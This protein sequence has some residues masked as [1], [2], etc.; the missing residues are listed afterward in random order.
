M[1][2]KNEFYFYDLETTGLSPK[3]DRIMQF[4]GQRTDMN[5]KPIGEPDNIF[6]K[7]TPDILPSPDAIMVTGIT[8]QQTLADGISE[9]EF[10]QYFHEHVAT[11]GTVF[12]GYNTVRFDDEFMRFL[13]YRNFYDAYTWQWRDDRGRWDLLD[14]V[15][16]TRA[17]R[18]AGMQWPV[19]GE[20]K[21]TNRLE[22]LTKVNGLQ[23]QNAHDALSDVSATI[24]IASLIKQQQPKLFSYLLGIR[25]K[26]QVQKI[27]ASGQPFIYT[28]GRYAAEF[29][30]T[31]VAMVVGEHPLQQGS[32]FVFD[33]RN[34]PTE[35]IGMTVEDI[36][37]RYTNRFSKDEQPLPIKLI[38]ANKCPAIA[39]LGVLTAPDNQR[40]GIDL[41]KV[42]EHFLA[43]AGSGDLADRLAEVL[44]IDNQQ[45]Q[46]QFV[47][48]NI[49][50]DTQLYN[51][52]FDSADSNKMQVV[53]ASNAE[54]LADFNPGFND[55]R[56][57]T[58][59]VRYKARQYPGSL[60]NAEQA[61][62]AEFL[63]NKMEDD[64]K[65]AGKFFERIAQLAITHAGDPK[66]LYL[67]QELQLYG[68]S[69]IPT[70][71]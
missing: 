61:V 50:V 30:K 17:L 3:D 55:P 33:L 8:P 13:N 14:V 54:T 25:N 28:S 9:A 41:A 2:P 57:E 29:E 60:T 22:L 66:K 47:E 53:R 42:K 51:G 10:L 24:A 69:I 1:Q 36:A 68:E 59:L 65:G 6:I 18:P 31:T 45:K 71:Y 4:A 44:R 62:W 70:S 15:R 49:D 52:F 38:Q 11:P 19:D 64:K 39:P 48:N 63:K 56:L 21:A 67:L 37:K 16:M 23:H 34:D 12:T 40:L 58:L 35:L 5:L 26:K 20:G 27:L 43:L 32:Y 46:Q 7:I